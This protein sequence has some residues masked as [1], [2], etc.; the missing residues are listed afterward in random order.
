MNPR[1]HPVAWFVA[2]LLA[3]A[4]ATLADRTTTLEVVSDG[5]RIEARVAGSSVAARHVVSRV[6]SVEITAMDSIQ[7]PGGLRM[8]IRADD[9]AVEHE[10]LPRRFRFPVEGIRP[11][12]DWE[13]DERAARGTVW[14][15]PIEVTGPFVF[16]AA[17]RG[18]FHHDLAIRLGGRDAVEIAFRRGL[19]NNDLFIRSRDGTTLAATSLDPTPLADLGALAA[20]VLR[21]AAVACCWIGLLKWLA[22]ITT[23]RPTPAARR[24]LPAWPVVAAIA[25]AAGGLSAWFA[26]SI[27]EGLP[28]VP[29]AV[30]YLLQAR[31]WLDGNLAG[32]VDSVSRQM[33]IPYTYMIDDRWL[34]HYPPAWPSVLATGLAV[35]APELVAPVLGALF[36]VLM[37]LVGRALD[38]P[39]LGLLAAALTLV[40]PLMRVIFGSMLSHAAA[41]TAVLAS[42]WLVLTALRRD[43]WPVAAAAGAALAAGF[44]MRPLTALSVGGVLTVVVLLHL[45][46][47]TPNPHVARVA[48]AWI[49]GGLI[50]AVPA[51]V[52]NA[53]VTGSPWTFPYAL[54]GRPMY[55]LANL[56]FGLRNLDAQLYSAAHGLLGLDILGLP[57][58]FT[59]AVTLSFAAVPFLL[60]RHRS[61]DVVLVAIVAVVALAHLGSRGHGLHGFGPR[62]LFETF[63]PLLLLTGR[64]FQELARIGSREGRTER[65]T[66]VVATGALFTLLSI[67]PGAALPGR[68]ELYRGYNGVDGS[69]DAQIA[70]AG[71]E[72]ALI[73]LPADDW[74]SW[75]MA[76]RRINLQANAELQFVEGP[77][78]DGLRAL[79]TGRPILIWDGSILYGPPNRNPELEDPAS[80]E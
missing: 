19:I 63:G 38:G 75:A 21:A 27:L 28:H 58:P 23:P 39:I 48:V 67:V 41:S 49:G 54:A 45:A 42:L 68:L 30:T 33:A 66:L 65:A 78:D 9:G 31:W 18:R 47:R 37:Y 36:V 60:R 13:I 79:A 2:A 29:D 62:Y 43:S 52:A 40:A 12:G 71:L 72:R 53:A 59:A 22:R 46:A 4:I 32:T 70:T 57:S 1:W 11:I 56:P 8:S 25:T 44:A 35:G 80:H 51:L 69:L 64:G 14:R 34:A 10:R 61:G 55:T 73:V 6:D 7:T 16:H 24:T 20:L 76:S 50:G 74:Q 5:G 77:L 3:F 17:F 15:L 26:V